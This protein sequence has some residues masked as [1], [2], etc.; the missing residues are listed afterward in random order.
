[1]TIGNAE[2]LSERL[3]RI[4]TAKKGKRFSLK[5]RRVTVKAPCDNKHDGQ[6]YCITHRQGFRNQMEKDSHISEL[7]NGY[8]RHELVWICMLHGPEQP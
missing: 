4:S 8:V 1:M 2:T 6:W 5:G 7:V 3:E